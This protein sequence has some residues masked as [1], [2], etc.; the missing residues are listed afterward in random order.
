M[1]HQTPGLRSQGCRNLPI[2]DKHRQQKTPP[3]SWEAGSQNL[4]KRRLAEP[5]Q[6]KQKGQN[7]PKSLKDAILCDLAGYKNYERSENRS[8]ADQWGRKE[9]GQRRSQIRD[10]IMFWICSH[11]TEATYSR[12]SSSITWPSSIICQTSSFSFC[13]LSS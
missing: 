4:S 13:R 8:P 10:G 7:G 3:Y 9:E 5:A 1:E 11:N 6:F 2:T 12:S